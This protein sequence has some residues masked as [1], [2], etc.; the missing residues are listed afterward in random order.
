MKLWVRSQERDILQECTNLSAQQ[1]ITPNRKHTTWAVV[2]NFV[3][4]G[5]YPTRERCLEIIDEV[6]ARFGVGEC[7]VMIYEMPQE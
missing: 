7:D 1:I 2:S 6:Q 3:R 5:E 4:V